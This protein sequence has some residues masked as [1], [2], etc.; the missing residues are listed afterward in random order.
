MTIVDF[1][2]AKKDREPHM[3][4]EAKC[5]SCK[6]KWV[7]VAPIGAVWLECPECT[8]TLGRFIGPAERNGAFW[9]CMCGNDLFKMAPD[10]VYC[11]VCGDWQSVD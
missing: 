5:L 7:S 6:Y 4:G 2:Q 8:L 11:P 10:G 1:E 3:S 9:R